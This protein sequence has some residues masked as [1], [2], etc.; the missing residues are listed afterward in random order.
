MPYHH[1]HRVRES[2]RDPAGLLW[3][4]RLL[5]ICHDAWEALLAEAGQPIHRLLTE[6]RF[7]LPI[8]H[9]ELDAAQPLRGALLEVAVVVKELSERS[10]RVGYA[11]MSESQVGAR[12]ETIHVAIDPSARKAI[13]LPAELAQALA[14]YR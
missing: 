3:P 2:E 12:A 10:V 1:L 4:E 8:V 5:S 6:G 9:V 11:V 14:P 13:P 7:G